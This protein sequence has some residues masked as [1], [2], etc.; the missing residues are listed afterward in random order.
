MEFYYREIIPCIQSLYGDPGLAR[1]LVFAPERH[2]TD[3]SRTCQIFSEMHTGNWWWS[4]QV[5][6]AS[7]LQVRVS[8]MLIAVLD[9]P[10]EAGTW[11]NLNPCHPLL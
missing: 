4:V 8:Q 6:D 9:V 5:C 3:A 2:Y 7:K 10:G 1:D 11:C